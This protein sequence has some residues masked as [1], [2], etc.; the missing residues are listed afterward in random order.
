MPLSDI[1]HVF[2]LM[3]ENRSFDHMLGYSGITGRLANDLSKIVSIEGIDPNN[4]PKIKTDFFVPPSAAIAND[5][6]FAIKQTD[7]GHEFEDVMVQLTGR[8]DPMLIAGS[9]PGSLDNSG[10]VVNYKLQKK[11][12]TD[13][14][15][16]I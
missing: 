1:K 3:L 11:A 14:L 10:F 7:P 4:P 15:A 13:N 9:Y 2:V 5:A 12:P 6:P 8:A 16:V